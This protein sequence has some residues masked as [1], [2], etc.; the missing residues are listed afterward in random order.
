MQ[1][2][3]DDY[4]KPACYTIRFKGHLDEGWSDSFENLS[5]THESDGTTT[6]CGLVDQTALHGVLRRVRDTGIVLISV[7]RIDA[8]LGD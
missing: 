1:G 8:K 4:D 2:T 7:A 3:P 6:L 5:L